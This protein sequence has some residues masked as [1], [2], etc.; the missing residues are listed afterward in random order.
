MHLVNFHALAATT[1]P[2]ALGHATGWTPLSTTEKLDIGTATGADYDLQELAVPAL[3]DTGPF[4]LFEYLWNRP[5]EIEVYP[6]GASYSS[7]FSF[8]NPSNFS[9]S[10]FPNFAYYSAL[11]KVYALPKPW[12]SPSVGMMTHVTSKPLSKKYKNPLPII[13]TWGLGVTTKNFFD[14]PKALPARLAQA[15][16]P[17]KV[18]RLRL[19]GGPGFTVESTASSENGYQVEVVSSQY[20]NA[21]WTGGVF[22]APIYEIGLPPL[23]SSTNPASK[24]LTFHQGYA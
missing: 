22:P 4:E 10:Q 6:P 5:L 20:N 18:Q 19:S 9:F 3:V 2:P 8:A 14:N 21:N 15:M 17:P 23:N 11:V 1:L 16:L 13:G 7:T 12:P 24:Q